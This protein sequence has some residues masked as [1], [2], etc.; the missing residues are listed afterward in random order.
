[1][2]HPSSD[3][4]VLHYYG[5][6]LDSRIEAHLEECEACR[7]EYR[8][9]QRVLNVV[10]S[11]PVPE[12]GPEYGVEVWNRVRP[13][14]RELRRA[15]APSF[16][17]LFG[18]SRQW[19]SAGAVAL[20]LCVAFAAGRFSMR[21]PAGAQTSQPVVASVKPQPGSDRVLLTA[22]GNHL[23]RMQM[24][25]REL[26]NVQPQSDMA[27]QREDVRDL[28]EANRLYRTTATYAGERS[29]AEELDELERLLVELTHLTPRLS[30]EQ[31]EDLRQRILHDGLLLK[32]KELGSQVRERTSKDTGPE[33]TL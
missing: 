33:T 26:C 24:V 30:R 2:N 16:W 25:L 15:E 11:Y 3:Q 1:M 31:R 10:D 29:V 7:S 17:W 22:V 13:A 6:P 4:L 32:L 9:L 21:P 12:R 14:V 27:S 19:A 28:L 23:D 20:L 18:V 8:S 5:E